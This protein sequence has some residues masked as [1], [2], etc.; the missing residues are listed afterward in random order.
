MGTH[1]ESAK[2]PKSMSHPPL[3][4]EGPSGVRWGAQ[5]HQNGARECQNDSQGSQNWGFGT[6]MALKIGATNGTIYKSSPP[7]IIHHHTI[8]PH[9]HPQIVTNPWI[10]ASPNRWNN[11]S[12]NPINES[13][14]QWIDASR[15]GGGVAR[16]AL[17]YIFIY[18]YIYNI[19][20]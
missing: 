3:T 13:M 8:P 15:H 5:G 2:P 16:R 18:I 9:R 10:N 19:Y 12:T 14:K 6:K 4:R 1:I 17:G 7:K 20:I 11:E